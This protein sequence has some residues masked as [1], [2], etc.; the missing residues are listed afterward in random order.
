MFQTRTYLAGLLTCFVLMSAWSQA[1]FSSATIGMLEARQIGP[2]VMSGRITDIVGVNSDPRTMY[3]GTAGGGIWKTS[4][5]GALF[6]PIFDKHCQS[7]G[8]IAID[9][10]HPDTIWAGTGES[11]MRNSVSIGNGIYRSTDAGKNWIR[12]GLEKTEHISK[13][14]LHPNNPN[15]IFV[16]APGPLWSDSPERG[17]FRSNDGGKTWEKALYINEKTGCADLLIDPVNPDIMYATTW[18]FRRT[19]YSFNSGGPGSAIYKSTDG[20]KNWRKLNK[21]LPEGDFGRVAIALAPSAPQNLLA[22]V[23]S[24]STGLY[25]SSDGGE[26]WKQQSSSWNVCGRPFYFST[27]VVDPTDPKRVYRPAYT[28]SIST[29]G[30]YSFTEPQYFGGGVHPDHH[31]L[32]INPQNTS[33]LFLG[34]DGGV[35]ISNDKGNSWNFLRNLPVGQFY[36]VAVD[37]QFP[38]NIYGGL[39]DNGSWRGPSRKSGGIKNG[40]WEDLYG[41][42]GFWV[43]PD[44]ENPDIVYA[45][46]QGG[47]IGRINTNTNEAVDIQPQPMLGEEKLRFNWNTPI[48]KSPTNKKVLYTGSEFLYKTENGGFTWKRLSPDLT[49]NNKQKQN[50]EASGGITVDNSSAENHCTIFAI[51]ESPLDSKL[52]WVGTDDGNLQYSADGGATWNNVTA[53]YSKAGIPAG[54]WVSSIEPGRHDRNTVFVTFD[55]HCYGDMNTYIAKS[56]DLGKNWTLFKSSEFTGFAHKILQD[57]VNQ[58]LLFAG[59]EMGLFA[60]I[61]GGVTWARMKGNI[62]EYCLVRDLVIHPAT[63]DL[64]IG[65]HGRAILIVDNITPLRNLNDSIMNS[66]FAFLPIPEVPVTA[67]QFGGGGGTAGEYV[68]SNYTEEA[69]ITY[70]LKDRVNTGDVKIQ[71]IDPQGQLLYEIPATK[72]KGINKVT[73][74]MRMKPPQS[75]KTGAQLDFAGFGSPLVTPGEYKVRLVKG[76]QYYDTQLKLVENPKS[77]HS[78]ADRDLQRKTVREV[79][80]MIEEMN[81]ELQR[82]VNIQDDLKKKMELVK[83]TKVKATMQVYNDSLEV[84]RKKMVATKESMGITGEERIREKI[85]MLFM[86]ISG[87]E[88]R[89][90]D[91]Q[92][93]RIKGLGFEISEVTKQIQKVNTTYLDKVNSSLIKAKLEKIALLT[94]EGWKEEVK[95]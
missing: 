43:Q 47:H 42:D 93:D 35:Y 7:I 16:A 19:P 3:V 94:K 92:V 5:G 66:D 46:Y 73:W 56:T 69:V 83:D 81:F 37:N 79:Y 11:N 22:I 62:P 28:F 34:T 50:Q 14:L 27:L 74:N 59:T 40:D 86:Q 41:G 32:W 80:T 77:A 25:I 60:T 58:Q 15:L 38:Y 21:G 39:Q 89:P 13:V 52:I 72:R 51:A 54:T 67:G 82:L 20:G 4:T 68:G 1:K 30:G 48:V 31:A 64:V 70:Y 29:D 44:D 61:D 53:N 95:P 36:H 8:A 57:H 17:L 2:A 85:N 78:Q 26:N 24:A 76:D 90:T 75:A 63:H 55:N 49:T 18:E 6:E 87:F 33:Q 10:A 45:E 23:E 9:Q 88:G 91:S 84:I 65:S 12:M 71:I